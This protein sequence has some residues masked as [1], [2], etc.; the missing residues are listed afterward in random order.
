M[1]PDTFNVEACNVLNTCG[2]ERT[3]YF[4]CK[5]PRRM[6]VENRVTMPTDDKQFLSHPCAPSKNETVH[7]D[8]PYMQCCPYGH[9]HERVEIVDLAEGCT[10]HKDG[11][12]WIKDQCMCLQTGHTFYQEALMLLNLGQESLYFI[13]IVGQCRS[14]HTAYQPHL[15]VII[16]AL[17]L[18]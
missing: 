1:P 18:K 16:I 5:K 15:P 7:V 2:L 8:F 9:M 4:C 11:G 3:D 13:V 12:M 10:F 6:W 14:W 17:S